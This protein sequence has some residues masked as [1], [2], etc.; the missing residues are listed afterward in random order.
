M[1]FRSAT[2][3]INESIPELPFE[4]E[5]LHAFGNPSLYETWYID[6][7]SA[8]GKSTFIMRLC[9]KLC[10]Y[11]KVLHVNLEEYKKLSFKKRVKRMKMSEHKGRWQEVGPVDFRELSKKL[12]SPK[13]ANFIVI[14]SIQ[15]MGL[16]FQQIKELFIDKFPKKSFI[17]ISQMKDGQPKGKTADDMKFEAGVKI[18]TIGFR[19]YCQGRYVED[20]ATYYTIW[21]EGA[22]KH[23]LTEK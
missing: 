11:G 14:D 19:A 8:S 12:E 22:I 6:G 20:A 13:M 23:Y 4:G 9:K 17:F 5:W 16:T 21:E 18:R 7:M 1:K 10:Q 15:Y 2:D 3:I